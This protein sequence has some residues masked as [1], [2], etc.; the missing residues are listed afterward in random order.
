MCLHSCFEPQFPKIQQQP[1]NRAPH[2]KPY[3]PKTR[4]EN[5]VLWY[6]HSFIL[7][8]CP[9]SK[10]S[11]KKRRDTV[12]DSSTEQYSNV[13]VPR[14]AVR[15][16]QYA[17]D[18]SPSHNDLSPFGAESG[19]DFKKQYKTEPFVPILQARTLSSHLHVMFPLLAIVQ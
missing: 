3:T 16:S 19:V 12:F 14:Q 18:P 9:E 7:C 15:T 10:K 6:K 17:Q 13:R 2:S 11:Y 1:T 4:K 8:T 5:F